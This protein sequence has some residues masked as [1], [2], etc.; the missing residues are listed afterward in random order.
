[1]G[2]EKHFQDGSA[3]LQ[4]PP[5]RCASVGMTKVV[6]VPPVGIGLWMNETADPS[7]SLGM[8]KGPAVLPIGVA[9]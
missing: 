7:A 3:E 9:T 4:I 8:T 5:L 2:A 6:L 1:M